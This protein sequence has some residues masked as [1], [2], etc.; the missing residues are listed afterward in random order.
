M[1]ILIKLVL[2]AVVIGI[3][4][5]ALARIWTKD[6]DILAFLKKPSESIPVKEET[7]VVVPAELNL[8]TSDWGK[9]GIVEIK[10][11]KSATTVYSLW[12]KLKAKNPGAILDDIQVGQRP[13]RSLSRRALR[14]STLIL[15]S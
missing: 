1:N 9:T 15:T 5:F 8:A 6:I 2:S 7:V 4:Y 14:E 11:T 3:A 12:V 10:N 13:D